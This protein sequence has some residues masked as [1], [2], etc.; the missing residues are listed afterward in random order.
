M[1]NIPHKDHMLTCKIKHNT[2]YE[3]DKEK[4]FFFNFLTGIANGGAHRHIPY[5]QTNK[6]I[7]TQNY[8]AFK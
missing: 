8:S 2:T 5:K 1:I 7:N 3:R 4:E 6:Q